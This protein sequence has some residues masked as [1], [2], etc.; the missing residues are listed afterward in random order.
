MGSSL[1]TGHRFL[2]VPIINGAAS[3]DAN[4]DPITADGRVHPWDA[5]NE[6]ILCPDCLGSDAG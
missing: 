2:S 1:Q 6:R 4:G 5:A 3:A